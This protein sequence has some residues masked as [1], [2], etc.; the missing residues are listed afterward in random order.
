MKSPSIVRCLFVFVLLLLLETICVRA[1]RTEISLSGPAWTLWQ[2]NAASYQAD[3]LYLPPVSLSVLP[4]HP[5]TGGWKVLNSPETV[6]AR[7][8]GTAEEFLQKTPGPA[9]DIT[10]VTWWTRRITLP[11]FVGKQ[12]VFLRF[13]AVRQ[14]AEIYIDQKLVGYDLIGNSPFELALGTGFHS[15]QVIQLAVRITDA[16]G[17]FDWRD[18]AT[19]PWG[20]YHVLTSH[21]FGGLTGDISLVLTDPVRIEDIAVLNTPTMTDIKVLVD[22]QNLDSVDRLSNLSLSI[23]EAKEPKLQIAQYSLKDIRLKAGS[24]HGLE[25]PVSAPQA[26]LWDLEHPELY[27]C[28]ATL[29]T[30]GLTEDSSSVRFGFRWFAPADIGKDACFRLNG[31]RIVLRTAISWGFWPVSGILPTEDLA[32]REVRVAKQL[33]QN[34]LN[35]HRC[36]G[37]PSVFDKADELGLLIYEEPGN[38]K[39]GDKDAFA[40]SMADV[41]LSRMVRRDRSHPSLVIYNLIN[42]D[43]AA[44][45]ADLAAREKS[46]RAVHALDP[47]RVVTRTSA[48]A[49]PGI[50]VDDP[51][52]MHMRPYDG[53]LYSK[54]W[55]DFH[56]AGGPA[57]WN[58]ALYKGPSEYYNRTTN[59]EEIVYWGEEGAIS[60]PPRLG[61]IKAELERRPNLGW[62]G[63]AYLDFYQQFDAFLGQKNLREAFPSVD[64]LT[65]ALGNVSLDHQGR[66]IQLMRLNDICDGYAVNGWESELIENHSGIVDCFRNPKGDPR[67][68][69]KYNQA[70]YLAVMPRAQIGQAG[71]SVKV[72]FYVINEL[73]LH[74][75][76][77]LEIECFDAH[78]LLLKTAS[79]S[80]DLLGGDRF[81]QLLVDE[82]DLPFGQNPGLTSIKARLLAPDKTVCAKGE[83]QV[84]CVEWK[85]AKI[86]GKG[87]LFG[88]SSA[89]REFLIT[90]KGVELPNYSD[91][92]GKL[93][94]L[95]VAR[96]P[97]GDQVNVIPEA[98]LLQPQSALQ[99]VVTSFYTDKLFQKKITER[100]DNA[101]AISVADGATPD[102]AFPGTEEY[103]VR[104]RAE[105]VPTITGT[106]TFAINAAGGGVRLQV[107][108]TVLI[109]ALNVRGRLPTERVTLHL[110]AGKAVSL[111]MEYSHT[112]G[113]GR[114]KLLWATPDLN[115]PDLDRLLARVRDEGTQLV[116][117]DFAAAWMPLVAKYSKIH[118]TG[119][120]KI[121]SAWIGG[122]HFVRAHALFSGLPVNDAMGWPYQAVVQNGNERYALQMEGEDFAAGAWHCNEEKIPMRLGTAVGVIPCGK[123]RVIF[124]TLAIS[125]QLGSQEG[126]AH[127]AK[128][129]LCNFLQLD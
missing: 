59:R 8:P 51:I 55:Y 11:T 128:K 74:G 123:G 24:R 52:K 61:L 1:A 17:N 15:G 99:G 125:D 120:F 89:L 129:L 94:W 102:P 75:P 29:D 77:Q 48:W 91:A 62:D 42:E 105:L 72:D 28:I 127:V 45:E 33:G 14:R 124:S 27:R 2:D 56:H 23:I 65:G 12:H 90:E 86:Q 18:G 98:Q 119:A 37:Q 76:H 83:D 38:W 84:L 7:I 96:A 93:D 34:M 39:G 104:W 30:K 4:T 81:G 106:Y 67:L 87:A 36:I 107:S 113:D 100:V 57:T 88:Q 46:V 53:N 71:E 58:Q 95:I 16:G 22:L 63:A 13:G 19:Y 109:D 64:A 78:G 101:V 111:L 5:P 110:V 118:Y 41:K 66:K 25:I 60:T 44:K 115:P 54:G 50:T 122:I 112:R 31:R 126:P 117:L 116:L 85:S 49:K 9:G 6:A 32:E 21:G 47:S 79:R 73:N 121:G 26:K 108:D 92:L 114:C 103:H 69:A 35:F 3:T 80:V 70:L 43:G 10:G 97:S 20:K 40:R 68:M 82:I